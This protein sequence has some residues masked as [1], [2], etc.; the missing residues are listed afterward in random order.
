MRLLFVRYE[1]RYETS[2][3]VLEL[4]IFAGVDERV[5]AAVD[6]HQYHGEVVEPADESDNVKE[7]R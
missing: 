5:D 1:L 2:N 4:A 6:D 7:Q 3:A